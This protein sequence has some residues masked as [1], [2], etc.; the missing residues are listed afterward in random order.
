VDHDGQRS[1]KKAMVMLIVG[2][3]TI[4]LWKIAEGD[5]TPGPALAYLSRYA[6]PSPAAW[7]IAALLAMMFLEIGVSLPMAAL[8]IAAAVAGGDLPST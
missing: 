4:V 7:A 2:V 1:L 6:P 8:C 5:H 3:G